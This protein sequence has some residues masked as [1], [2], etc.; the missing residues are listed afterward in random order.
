[1]AMAVWL[2]MVVYGYGYV[3]MREDDKE[4]SY[5]HLWLPLSDVWS[6]M[7]MAAYTQERPPNHRFYGHVW[8]PMAMAVCT[9][10]RTIKQHSMATPE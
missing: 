10:E 8:S 9:R 2:C 5:G 3:Y 7:A 1:M 6:S 4:G